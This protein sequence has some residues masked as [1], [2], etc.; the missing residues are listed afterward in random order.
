MVAIILATID[1]GDLRIGRPVSH[2]NRPPNLLIRW[3]LASRNFSL[4]SSSTTV[5]CNFIFMIHLPTQL[6]NYNS[7]PL[8]CSAINIHRRQCEAIVWIKWL[9]EIIYYELINT[10][11]EI[12]AIALPYSKYV[13][14]LAIESAVSALIARK[15]V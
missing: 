2:S 1:G 8:H 13:L 12:F 6:H 9:S 10:Q 5:N 14:K 7:Q 3:V 4:I 15:Y 11:R